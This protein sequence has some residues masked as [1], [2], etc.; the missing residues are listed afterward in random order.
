MIKKSN[1]RPINPYK[2]VKDWDIAEME[3]F[4][5]SV[6]KRNENFYCITPKYFFKQRDAHIK[7]NGLDKEDKKKEYVDETSCG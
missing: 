2:K 6:L 7:F 1:G 5:Y 3:Y 4:W